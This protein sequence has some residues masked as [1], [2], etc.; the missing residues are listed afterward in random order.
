VPLAD[1]QKGNIQNIPCTAKVLTFADHIHCHSA[2]RTLSALAYACP[3]TTHP[4][5]EWNFWKEK[6]LYAKD[7]K[8]KHIGWCRGGGGGGGGVVVATDFFFW[9]W[10]C[11][12]VFVQG[13]KPMC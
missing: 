5:R 2:D 9:M 6:M 11:F 10:C 3:D 1:F 13:R 12:V 8:G 7:G 4:G